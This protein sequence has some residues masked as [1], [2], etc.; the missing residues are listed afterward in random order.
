MD[1]EKIIEKNM[2]MVF[3][4]AIL[5][6]IDRCDKEG[7]TNQPWNDFTT[8]HLN[9][10]LDAEWDEWKKERKLIELIDVINHAA[11]LYLSLLDDLP[12]TYEDYCRVFS[13]R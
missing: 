7:N 11:F 4:R 5:K 9:K 1:R 13:N 10:R 2:Q 8:E 12:L 3:D 6:V